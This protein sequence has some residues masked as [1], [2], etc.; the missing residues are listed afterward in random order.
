M[1]L[2]H[3]VVAPGVVVGGVLLARDQLLGVEELAVGASTNLIWNR[4]KHP[5]YKS[6][7]KFTGEFVV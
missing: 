2:A 3:G 1:L 4:S 7:R 5:P 6:A